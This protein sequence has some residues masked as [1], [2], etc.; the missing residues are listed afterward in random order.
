MKFNKKMLLTMV[1]V[2][3]IGTS[4]NLLYNYD[5]NAK[6]STE[7]DVVAQQE[8]DIP[9]APSDTQEPMTAVSGNWGTSTWIFD[10]T[11]GELSIDEGQLG[12]VANA[13]WK[14]TPPQILAGNITSI[15]FLNEVVIPTNST[16]LFQG[17]TNLTR[18]EGAELLNTSNV[19]S[20]A[21]M[22]SGLLKLEFIDLSNFDTSSVTT[23]ASMFK[24]A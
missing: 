4:F 22:F 10:D 17:L 2:V 1:G 16:G 8:L 24:G 14:G 7:I 18:I 20:M 13:P 12:A 21:D 6:E 19:T 9:I 5:L 23:M 15:V 11:T 3:V